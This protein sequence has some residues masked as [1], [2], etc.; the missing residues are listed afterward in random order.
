MRAF[1]PIRFSLSFLSCRTFYVAILRVCN[2][3]QEIS[4]PRVWC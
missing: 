3:T 2:K 1:K 4:S